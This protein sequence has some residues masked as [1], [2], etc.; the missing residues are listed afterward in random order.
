VT[1]STPLA[2]HRQCRGVAQVVDPAAGGSG[3]PGD[4]T[5]DGGRVQLVAGPGGEPQLV[6]PFVLGARL[7]QQ[8]ESVGD[9]H[10]PHLAGL[11]H[12]RLD[13]FG[14]RSARRG[15]FACSPFSPPQRVCCTGCVAVPP[16]TAH[17]VREVREQ[18]VQQ[19]LDP[20]PRHRD[21][22]QRLQRNFCLRSDL[23]RRLYVCGLRRPR[24]EPTPRGNGPSVQFSSSIWSCPLTIQLARSTDIPGGH[25]VP[26]DDFSECFRSC[27]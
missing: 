2:S 27:R 5:L 25:A 13:P 19:C 8:Q 16:G 24:G 10:A 23:V 11:R 1:G 3:G 21:S 26:R 18:L 9:G 15:G 17:P 22:R 4:G 12:L 6:R 20:G 14:C 7:D